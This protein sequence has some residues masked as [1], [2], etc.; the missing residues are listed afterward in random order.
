MTAQSITSKIPFRL[1]IGVVGDIPDA[2]LESLRGLLLPEVMKLFDAK[3]KTELDK[4]KHTELA[5]SFVRLAEAD[6]NKV[7]LFL[8]DGRPSKANEKILGDAR[9]R[10][11]PVITLKTIRPF[12]ISVEVGHGLNAHSVSALER[13]NRVEVKQEQES[14]IE[15]VYNSLYSEDDGLPPDIK[16]LVRDK[17]LPFYVRASLLAKS[18]QKLYRRAGLVVYSFSTMAVAAMAIGTLNH[19]LSPYAFGLA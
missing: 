2:A 13:F 14:Y 11:Q 16:K 9:A 3:S 12:D 1:R 17:L 19:Q 4:A 7:D 10:T 18:S 6:T 15:N 5:I 8:S